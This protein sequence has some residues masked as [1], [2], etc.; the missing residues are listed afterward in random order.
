MG[1]E[2]RHSLGQG[3]REGCSMTTRAI[4]RREYMAAWRAA[5][6][7]KLQTYFLERYAMQKAAGVHQAPERKARAAAYYQEN[8]ERIQAAHSAYKRSNPEMVRRH[9]QNRR[10]RLIGVG[11]QLS[12][13]I[14]ARLLKLQKNKCANCACKLARHELD[15][16][17]AISNG[18]QNVDENMQLL[19]PTCNRRKHAKD[20]I[21]FAQEQGRLL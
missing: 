8:K 4:Q 21:A 11:G 7:E 12:K 10:S 2:Q 13:D 17:V 20:P 15:H 16:I 6:K 9:Y 14:E 18:G 3:P 19:C 1:Q 5:N